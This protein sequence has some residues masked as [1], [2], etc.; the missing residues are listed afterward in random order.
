MIFDG[1]W[2]SLANSSGAPKSGTAEAVISTPPSRVL[3]HL[4]DVGVNSNNDNRFKFEV[5][6][7]Y[8]PA[9]LGASFPAFVIDA[10]LLRRAD[11]FSLRR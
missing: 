6:H 4:L 5:A 11:E 2:L 8:H 3:A 9:L 10:S 7:I 1:R